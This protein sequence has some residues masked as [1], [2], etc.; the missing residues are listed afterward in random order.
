MSRPA[1][2]SS[3]MVTRR[4]TNK[5]RAVPKVSVPKELNDPTVY[6]VKQFIQ[7][8]WVSQQPLADTLLAGNSYNLFS[9]ALAD[10]PGYSSFVSTF[11]QYRIVNME[12]FFFP[13]R[14]AGVVASAPIANVLPPAVII[15]ADYDDSNVPALFTTLL[16]YQNSHMMDPDRP[17]QTSIVPRTT[18]GSSNGTSLPQPPGTWIDI[19]SATQKHFGIKM[20]ISGG[21]YAQTELWACQVSVRLTIDLKQ[22]R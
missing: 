14:R 22:V 6:R 19:A 9:P 11:D 5:W 3:S 17:Y 10:V 15:A 20:G 21:V 7:P 16:E 4:T 18:I 13:T 1:S 12:I 2:S 8:I